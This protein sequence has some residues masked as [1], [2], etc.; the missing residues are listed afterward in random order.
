MRGL[1][2][3]RGRAGPKVKVNKHH[4]KSSLV[5][6][7]TLNEFYIKP[8]ILTLRNHCWSFNCP[9][10]P[11][12]TLFQIK[13]EMGDAV[14]AGSGTRWAFLSRWSSLHTGWCQSQWETWLQQPLQREGLKNINWEDIPTLFCSYVFISVSGSSSLTFASKFF[15][16]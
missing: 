1:P 5:A 9:S 14:R 2:T 6:G 16:Q 12:Q 8:Y 15:T 10:N 4:H 13:E 7:W 11:T 3:G